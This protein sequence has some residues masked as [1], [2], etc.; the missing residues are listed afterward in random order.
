MA[1]Y[2]IMIRQETGEIAQLN[3]T[4]TFD[5]EDD[6]WEYIDT[7]GLEFQH[8]ECNVFVEPEASPFGTNFW[9]SF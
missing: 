4:P 9:V 2:R 7:K 3:D 8:P 5:D 1:A 6:A